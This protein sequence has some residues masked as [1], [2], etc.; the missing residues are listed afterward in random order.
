MSGSSSQHGTPSIGPYPIAEPVSVSSLDNSVS[1]NTLKDDLEC[2]AS[3]QDYADFIPYRLLFLWEVVEGLHTGLD[4]RRRTELWLSLIEGGEEDDVWLWVDGD[5]AWAQ[6]NYQPESSALQGLTPRAL[7]DALTALQRRLTR[8]SPVGQDTSSEA[9]SYVQRVRSVGNPSS[10]FLAI[11]WLVS[12]SRDSSNLSLSQGY[13]PARTFNL[14]F[15]V[16][17]WVRRTRGLPDGLPSSSHD[18]YDSFDRTIRDS[19]HPCYTLMLRNVASED[20]RLWL[21][22]LLWLYDKSELGIICFYQAE[23]PARF[24]PA[25]SWLFYPEDRRQQPLVLIKSQRPKDNLGMEHPKLLHAIVWLTATRHGSV[26]LSDQKL[27]EIHASIARLSRQMWD[28]SEAELSERVQAGKPN[29]IF[30][31]WMNVYPREWRLQLG[32]GLTSLNWRQFEEVRV[33]AANNPPHYPP[34]NSIMALGA[35]LW[36]TVRAV[37]NVGNSKST[38]K[39]I[40][41]A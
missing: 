37:Q 7:Q 9:L 35:I 40:Q 1:A 11:A 27:E 6:Q 14:V 24:L 4:I 8:G 29:L 31:A 30:L 22:F 26:A 17:V 15:L 19:G 20:C 5:E 13:G 39:D 23:C 16:T 12:T 36:L 38:L 21:R 41:S 10:R 25:T 3:L 32:G 34:T 18:V 2:V 28:K 33:A